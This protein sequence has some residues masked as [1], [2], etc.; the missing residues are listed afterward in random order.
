MRRG[1]GRGGA[2]ADAGHARAH[3]GSWTSAFLLFLYALPF[4]LAYV[5]LGVA[6]GALILFLSVQA[7]MLAGALLAGERIHWLE[8]LGIVVALA[9]LVYLVAPGLSA[10]DPAGA[11][12]MAVA[13]AAWGVYSLRG[14]RSTDPIRDTAANF[15]RSMLFAVVAGTAGAAFAGVHASGRGLLLAAGSG[16]IASAAG[17]AAWFAAL[18]RLKTLHAAALQLTVPVIAAAGGIAFLAE[19]ITARLIVAAGLILGGVCFALSGRALRARTAPGV[20]KEA[21]SV[22]R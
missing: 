7:T 5:S 3:A 22:I 18:R 13:G 17:Y 1:A 15:I 2:Q 11:L 14:R 21:A 10:P 9:G 8:G 19:P 6:T 20:Q 4:S 12:L 16:V